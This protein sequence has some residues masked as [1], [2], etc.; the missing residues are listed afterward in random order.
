MTI[1]NKIYNRKT[2][3]YIA[4][5]AANRKRLGLKPKR[6][7]SRKVSRKASRRRAKPTKGNCKCYYKGTEPS[8]KGKGYCAHCGH[9]GSERI[10]IDG[11]KWKIKR[12]STGS[13]YWARMK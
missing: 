11:R 12:R 1:P 6:K 2:K 9:L 13:L 8:P 5:T 7:A 10:G 3:R 4:D